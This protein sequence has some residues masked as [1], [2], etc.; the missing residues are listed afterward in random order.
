M[1]GTFVAC[2][3]PSASERITSAELATLAP[4]QQHSDGLISGLDIRT[5]DTLIVAV[6]LQ[7]YIETDD[8]VIAAMQRSAV[9]AWRSA[10]IASHPHQ[11]ATLHVRFIDFI[12]RTVAVKSTRVQ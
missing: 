1:T 2:T 12:G 3:S 9:A 4:L 5:P 6:D 11:K 8:D 7:R 10:W